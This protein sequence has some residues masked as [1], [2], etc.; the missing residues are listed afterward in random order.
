MFDRLKSLINKYEVPVQETEIVTDDL[1]MIVLL[2]RETGWDYE[3]TKDFVENTPLRELKAFF[4]ELT[5]QREVDNYRR[6]EGLAMVA[7]EVRNSV[8]RK[9]G[10]TYQVRDFIGDIPVRKK[11]PEKIRKAAEKAGIEIPKEG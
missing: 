10:K 3:Y 7:R 8:P 2:I 6:L 5:Y 11:V 9:R 1:E 4:E